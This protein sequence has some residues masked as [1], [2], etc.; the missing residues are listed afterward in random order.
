VAKRAAVGKSEPKTRSLRTPDLYT[1]ELADRIC[2]RIV[3]LAVSVHVAAASEGVTST[4]TVSEW[5]AKSE[6][7]DP[8]YA[9]FSQKL[10]RARAESECLLVARSLTGGKGSANAQWLLERRFH[11]DYSR[12]D[13]LTVAGDE[14]QPLV[15][16]AVRELRVVAAAL[17]NQPALAAEIDR[18]LEMR[19]VTPTP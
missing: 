11:H 9:G 5:V 18:A 4:S 16:S 12:R 15:V 3:S 13:H 14:T 8:R 10:A 17:A 6:A 19:D 7:G 1:P 2:R